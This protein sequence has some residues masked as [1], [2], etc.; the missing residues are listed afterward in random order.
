VR[1]YPVET[2]SALAEAACRA[3]GAGQDMARS[4]ARASLSASRVG[5]HEVGLAHLVDHLHSLREGRINGAARPGID[6]PAPALIRV[7][8][9]GGIAQHGFDLVFDD[10]VQRAQTFGL[11]LLAQHNTYPAGELGYFAR[12][13]AEVGLVGLSAG[14]AHALMAVAAG[15]G[16][17][18]STNPLA[19][20]A[21]LADGRLPLVI[22]QASS[23][24]AFVN[25]LRAAEAGTTLPEGWALDDQ[26]RPTTDPKA[27]MAGAL[28]PFGGYKGAN[29]ALMVEVLAA[30]LTG[31]RWS[32]DTGHFLTGDASP[33]G[34]MVV[35]ALSPTLCAPD[36][37]DRLTVHLDRLAALGLHIPGQ[38]RAPEG[39]VEADHKVIAT[40]ERFSQP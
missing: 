31:G 14:N 6:S 21:P 24:T 17:V 36:F 5:R 8:A 30:G 34:G 39:W 4:L 3:C 12:R 27:A 20:A 38:S 18:F 19:F 1:R 33:G 16:K 9:D 23:A 40:L 25:I 28:L 22:D 32:M 7:D 15:G 26:R 29:I 10:L 35:L 2:V 13:L 11:A 37:A